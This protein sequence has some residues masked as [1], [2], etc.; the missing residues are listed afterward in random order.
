MPSIHISTENYFLKYTIVF[1][2]APDLKSPTENGIPKKSLI[3]N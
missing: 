2:L 3:L 1:F